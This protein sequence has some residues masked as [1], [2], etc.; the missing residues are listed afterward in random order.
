MRGKMLDYVGGIQSYSDIDGRCLGSFEVRKHAVDVTAGSSFDT[1]PE[2]GT[3]RQGRTPILTDVCGGDEVL[4]AVPMFE[5]PGKDLWRELVDWGVRVPDCPDHSQRLEEVP[6]D[7]ENLCS[8]RGSMERSC[9]NLRNQTFDGSNPSRL[10]NDEL[11][12]SDN[13][14]I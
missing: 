9:R 5:N 7:G 13:A 11:S 8:S 4:F 12:Q 6:L 3:G 14:T 1:G 2:R 10:L